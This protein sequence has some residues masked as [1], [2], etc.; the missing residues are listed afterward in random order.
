ML[1]VLYVCVYQS[2]GS[3]DTSYY[4]VQLHLH[5]NT[6]SSAIRYT[7]ATLEYYARF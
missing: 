1:Q 7:V 4:R 3:L 5:I 2:D 6:G